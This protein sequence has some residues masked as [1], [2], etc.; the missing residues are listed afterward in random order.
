MIQTLIDWLVKAIET[1]GYPG[2]AIAVFLESFFAPIPSEIILPFTGFVASTGSLN[3]YLVIIFA[4]AAAFL[5]SLPFY[6]LGIWGEKF[7][8]KFLDKFGKY[9]FIEKDDVEW[10]FN[11]FYK[12]GE[13]LVFLGRLIPVVRTFISFP[14]GVTKMKFGKFS[15][16]TFLGSLLWNILLTYTGYL[17]GDNWEII[18]Q[19]VA[20]YEKVIVALAIVLI[21]MYIARGI[22]K[23]IK[24]SRSRSI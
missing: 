17:M 12:Y 22:Y 7:V 14:A 4:T 15:I 2:V 18:G 20:K 10:V 9:L 19:W 21:V 13:R 8:Y 16:Y 3:I 24:H 5:G 6:I 1:L 23:R 11:Q